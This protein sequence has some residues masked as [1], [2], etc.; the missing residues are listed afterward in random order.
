M[1]AW[2]RWK[3][4]RHAVLAF[5][6]LFAWSAAH[7]A[8][9]AGTAGSAGSS[10]GPGGP[11]IVA[12]VER[13]ESCV[14]GAVTKGPPAGAAEVSA[15]EAHA[16]P[17]GSLGVLCPEALPLAAGVTLAG[18]PVADYW[19]SPDQWRALA[20]RL[21]RAE[22][23]TASSEAPDV[24]PHL[25]AVDP[26][27]LA[28]TVL[29]ELQQARATVWLR[30]L[31]RR[32]FGP[33]SAL[34]RWFDAMPPETG[35]A[36]V[37]V[38]LGALLL[39]AAALCS[40]VTIWLYRTLRGQSPRRAR[41]AVPLPPQ[42]ADVPL[43]GAEEIGQLPAS[44]QALAWL[45]LGVERALEQGLVDRV[46]ARTNMEIAGAVDA[47]RPEVQFARLA[48]VADLCLYRGATPDDAQL[49][50]SRA[51]VDALETTPA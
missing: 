36:L 8:G 20:R 40:V 42:L 22:V 34:A 26:Q 29:S 7:G 46:A 23:P 35:R 18:D 16:A 25:R 51:V 50:A 38:L 17:A 21:R 43:L 37:I 2:M 5:L 11:E 31:L 44:A 10:G 15:A 39:L 13:L 32:T 24:G 33:D 41:G 30:D 4:E 19:L 12:F 49:A 9:G 27:P 1:R 14:E 47:L 6:L 28:S 48:G 3:A 45:R